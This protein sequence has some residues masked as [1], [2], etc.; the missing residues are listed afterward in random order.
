MSN[1]SEI[2]AVEVPIIRK[3]VLKKKKYTHGTFRKVQTESSAANVLTARAKELA[4]V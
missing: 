4:P 1:Y 2:M 3:A